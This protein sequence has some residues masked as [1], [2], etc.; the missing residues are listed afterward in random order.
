MILVPGKILYGYPVRYYTVVCSVT[1]SDSII[2]MKYC[3]YILYRK[4]YKWKM[5]NVPTH[6]NARKRGIGTYVHTYI[7]TYIHTQKC[8]HIQL[9]TYTLTKTER[10]KYKYRYRYPHADVQEKE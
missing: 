10:Y 6:T 1:L 2:Y 4:I 9:H 8:I 3:T 5:K 7:L